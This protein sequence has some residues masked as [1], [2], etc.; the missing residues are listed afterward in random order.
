[1]GLFF[2]KKKED[3]V[4]TINNNIAGNNLPNTVD[5]K[6]FIFT[7]IVKGIQGIPYNTTILLVN[8]E[9]DNTLDFIYNLTNDKNNNVTIKF[10]KNLV[11]EISYR[12]AVRVQTTPKKSEEKETKSLLLSAVA[13]GGNPILQTLGGTYFNSLFESLDNNYSKVEFNTYYEII[14]KVNYNNQEF[15]ILLNCDLKPEEFINSF[16]SNS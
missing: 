2:N 8:N 7:S 1:M 4:E 11:H 3:K 16:K 5:E 10:Q 12:S 15:D 14:L 9:V 13:F 6:D